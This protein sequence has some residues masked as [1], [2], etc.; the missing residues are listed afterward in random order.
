MDTRFRG[1][2]GKSQVSES[3][4]Y[5]HEG[6]SMSNQPASDR[7]AHG[8]LSLPALT[9]TERSRSK[10]GVFRARPDKGP[11]GGGIV[12]QTQLRE[13]RVQIMRCGVHA[14]LLAIHG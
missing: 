4:G 8:A 3:P 6:I 14:V 5:I 2:D 9:C 7:A 1:Y 13:Q 11:D 10:D 12:R